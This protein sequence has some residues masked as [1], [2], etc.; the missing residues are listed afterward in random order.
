[1]HAETEEMIE[2]AS[3]E[4]LAVLVRSLIRNGDVPQ[5]KLALVLGALGQ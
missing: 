4:E 3:K 1:M 5:E 2:G